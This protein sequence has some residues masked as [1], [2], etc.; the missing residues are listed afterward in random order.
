MC[1]TELVSTFLKKRS[2]EFLA[3]TD[4]GV[5][6]CNLPMMLMSAS[7]GASFHDSWI[8]LATLPD[9]SIH[10]DFLSF[11]GCMEQNCG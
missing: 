5:R 10:R 2:S 8:C 4:L 1:V 11:L 7:F 6:A 3:I 9:F